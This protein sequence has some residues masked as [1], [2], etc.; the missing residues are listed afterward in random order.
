MLAL[1][2]DSRH[3]M[4]LVSFLKETQ[5]LCVFFCLVFKFLGKVFCG[6]RSVCFY[7]SN[8]CFVAVSVHCGYKG[9][10]K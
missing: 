8:L 2:L 4:D 9:P 10:D 5:S 1:T 7:V 3:R 6:F